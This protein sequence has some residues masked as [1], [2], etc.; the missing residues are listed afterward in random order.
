[1]TRA[2]LIHMWHT[3]VTWLIYIWH[4]SLKTHVKWHSDV[5]F[6]CGIPMWDHSFICDITRASLI[7]MSHNYVTW[8]THMWH[9]SLMCDMAH[10]YVTWLT[11]RWHDSLHTRLQRTLS[12]ICDSLTRDMTRSC[13]TWLAHMWHDSPVSD[14]THPYVTWLTANASPRHSFLNA[15]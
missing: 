3:Y 7:H 5:L 2:S 10:P 15:F 9:H 12:P 8:P 1:M 4:N 14:T 11:H 13:V 6:M